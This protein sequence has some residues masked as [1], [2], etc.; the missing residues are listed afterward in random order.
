MRTSNE[1]AEYSKTETGLAEL[2]S[3]LANVAYDV[4][5]V[6]GL[7]IAKA[8]RAEVR[9]LRTGLE[10]MRKSIKA[11]SLAH[12]KLIDAEAK[13]ITDELLKLETPIDEVIKLREAE[14]EAERAAREA[15]EKARVMAITERIA[16][17]RQYVE[18]AASCPGGTG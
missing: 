2:R 13:R 10:A 9:G 12:C 3:R 1:I 15:A 5:T 8:D 16:G 11:P 17:I 14:L 4:T 6:K 7:A 18:L